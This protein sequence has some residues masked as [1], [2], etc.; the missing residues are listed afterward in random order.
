MVLGKEFVSKRDS[1]V[2]AGE[3]HSENVLSCILHK[4]LLGRSNKEGRNWQAM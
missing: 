4:I 2:E 3:L 1:V